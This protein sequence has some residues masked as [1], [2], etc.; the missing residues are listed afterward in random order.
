MKALS[1]AKVKNYGKEQNKLFQVVIC[2]FQKDQKCFYQIYGHRT[3]KLQNIIKSLILMEENIQISFLVLVK[4]LWVIEIL[5]L[6]WF[7][8]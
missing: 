3:L 7:L 4:I 5:S 6:R 1:L 2:F 8:R